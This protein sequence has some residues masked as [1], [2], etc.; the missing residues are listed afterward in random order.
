MNQGYL[1]GD[2]EGDTP[3][4]DV[5]VTAGQEYTF[6]LGNTSF[7]ADFTLILTLKPTAAGPTPTPAP[8]VATVT[9][10]GN[11]DRTTGTPGKFVF[12]LSA[13]AT[14]DVKLGY[15]TAGTAAVGTD[16]KMLPGSVTIPAGQTTAT[17]KVKPRGET[18]AATVAV[19]LKLEAGDGYTVGG[20]SSAKVKIID[21]Q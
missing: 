20:A 6:S 10:K 13:A 1:P 19:K 8:P 12:A 18:D 7:P 9:A 5:A 3:A 21:G 4:P 17:L 11:A 16:Y 15:K 14:S 2:S